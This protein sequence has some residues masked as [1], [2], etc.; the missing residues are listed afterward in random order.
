MGSHFDR[1]LSADFIEKLAA[2]ARRGG[3]WTDVLADPKLV[4]AL[5]GAPIWTSTGAGNASFA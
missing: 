2:E 4:V 1:A 3:W 5:R